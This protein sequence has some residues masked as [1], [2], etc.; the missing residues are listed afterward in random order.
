MSA[1]PG[2]ATWADF[3]DISLHYAVSGNGP[4]SLILV[5]EL[6]GTLESWDHVVPHLENDFRILR[7]S[8]RGNGLSEK[9]R[10]PY[11]MADLVSDIRRLV[12]HTGL[13]PPYRIAGLASGAAVALAFAHGRTDMAGLALCAPA[14]QANPERARYLTER[15]E[16]AMRDGM[17]AIIDMV[18]A[19][20]F[21]KELVR[22]PA[23]YAEHRARFLA[24]DPVCYSFANK[25]LAE[26]AV[27]HMLS[28]IEA[29]VLLVAGQHDLMRPPDYVRSLLPKLKRGD[30]TTV[31][32]GHIMIA[33]APEDVA[34]AMKRFFLSN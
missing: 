10:R 27:E 2:A 17:R 24:L 29:P 3:S 1:S 13:R 21:Q 6:A 32:A 33:Q 25:V 14:L 31:D 8:Q 15:S 23:I 34:A 26:V 5:H 30:M 18:F 11:A 9:I 19:R 4:H 20:S 16:T 7:A 22:D 12:E 28:E